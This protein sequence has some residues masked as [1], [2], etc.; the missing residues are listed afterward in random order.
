MPLVV[1]DGTM[2]EGANAYCGLD[3]AASWLA[4]RGHSDWPSDDGSVPART[5]ALIK[6]ADYLNGLRWYGRKAA[7]PVPRVMAWPRVGAR[8]SGGD[9]IPENVVP[10]AVRAANAMLAR[11]VFTGVDLQPVLE[12]GGKIQSE[13][14]GSLSTSYFSDA[15]T[16]DVYTGL[17]DMLRGLAS[18]FMSGTATTIHVATT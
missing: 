11:L 14:V 3:F 16:R 18:D 4:D 6:A 10:Y 9:S 15:P 7:A 13:S 8:D 1:E 2:P 12:R 17:A 5:A